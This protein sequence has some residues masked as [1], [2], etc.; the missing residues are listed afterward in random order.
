MKTAPSPPD[1]IPSNINFN[2]IFTVELENENIYSS[3]DRWRTI[4]GVASMSFPTFHELQAAFAEMISDGYMYA[5]DAHYLM[6]AVEHTVKKI[7]ESGWMEE[8]DDNSKV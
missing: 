4:D 3:D 1:S 5:D 2:L 6:L 7:I 8:E